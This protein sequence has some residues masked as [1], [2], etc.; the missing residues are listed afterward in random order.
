MKS[1]INR[2]KSSKIEAVVVPV[3][4]VILMRGGGPPG[5]RGHGAHC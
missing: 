3:A 1:L 2:S 4:E 5:G